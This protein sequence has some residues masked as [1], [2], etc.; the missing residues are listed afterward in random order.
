[1]LA[2]SQQKRKSCFTSPIVVTQYFGNK[3]VYGHKD[4]YAQWGL[5]G[6]NGLD[7][8]PKEDDRSLFNV[9]LGEVVI[10]G[11]NNTYGI[12]V[13]IWNKDRR[14]VEIHNHLDFISEALRI[15]IVLTSRTFLGKMGNTGKSFGAHNHFA[16]AEVDENCRRINYN[17]G[18]KGWIDPLPFLQLES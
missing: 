13:G 2:K 18:Y 7:V 9:L 10:L 3:D 4:Y 16:M 8:K 15:G 17:N 1:M 6:H 12:R 5:K 14:L 11:Y